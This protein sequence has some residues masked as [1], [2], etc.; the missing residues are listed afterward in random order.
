MKQYLSLL[1]TM[2]IKMGPQAKAWR[3]FPDPDCQWRKTG[4]ISLTLHILVTWNP[5]LPDLLIMRLRRISFLEPRTFYLDPTKI[6]SV[7]RWWLLS[8][9]TSKSTIVSISL[10]VMDFNGFSFRINS[11]HLY[12]WVKAHETIALVPC[13]IRGKQKRM[14]THSASRCLSN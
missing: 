6:S 1:K 7:G 3:K 13:N 11:L 8:I 5:M 4:S 14:K 9:S 12:P 2:P 10:S